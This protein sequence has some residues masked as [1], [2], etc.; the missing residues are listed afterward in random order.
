MD[1]YRLLGYALNHTT[2]QDL[3]VGRT[4]RLPRRGDIAMRRA[5]RGAS[6][7]R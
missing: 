7:R 6:A 3:R 4:T 2:E 5:R 1:Q